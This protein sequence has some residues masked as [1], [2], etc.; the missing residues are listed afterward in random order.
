ML[1]MLQRKPVLGLL[2][3][4]VILFLFLSSA[5]SFVVVH[6]QQQQQQQTTASNNTGTGFSFG[7]SF[8]D[9]AVPGPA[10]E[11]SETDVDGALVQVQMYMTILVQNKLPDD[12]SFDL[13]VAP[14]AW[15]YDESSRP[16][17]PATI[18]VTVTFH[19]RDDL[20]LNISGDGCRP[21]EDILIAEM[22]K[23]EGVPRHTN[24][25]A[26]WVKDSEPP[27]NIFRHI[28]GAT[29]FHIGSST[30]I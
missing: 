3:L 13:Q 18:N 23:G 25:L 7:F 20:S 16:D 26:G 8:W 9:D 1:V 30:T 19:E 6:A 27:Q 11:I 22:N 15:G 10:V 12:S 29:W 5:P 2:S 14:S 4:S 24:E 17:Y 21:L 28:N